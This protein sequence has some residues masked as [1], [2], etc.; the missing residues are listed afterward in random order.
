MKTR[1]LL[2]VVIIVILLLAG[3][4]FG[5]SVVRTGTLTFSAPVYEIEDLVAE[6]QQDGNNVLVSGK[7]KN[8]GHSPVKGYVI[9]HFKNGKGVVVHSVET[10]VNKNKPFARGKSGIF[11]TLANIENSTGIQNVVIEF[12]NK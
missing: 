9:V 1:Y 5:G 7:I 10:E 8:L 2:P 12:V 6:L 4:I 11:E 3:N